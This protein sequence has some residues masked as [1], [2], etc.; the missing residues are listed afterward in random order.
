LLSDGVVE[1]C[2]ATG[3]LFGFERT[4]EISRQ[5]AAQIVQDD[6]SFGQQ[7][8]ITVLTIVALGEPVTL[9]TT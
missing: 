9:Q 5:S 2:N 1:A 8:D 7:D 6:Q 4:R 3:E